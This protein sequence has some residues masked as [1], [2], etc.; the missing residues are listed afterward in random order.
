MTVHAVC[1]AGGKTCLTFALSYL[2]Q[3]FAIAICQIWQSY[4]ANIQCSQINDLASL[5]AMFFFSLT[6]SFDR[7]GFVGAKNFCCIFEDWYFELK[8]EI[9]VFE[10]F[11]III[12][13]TKWDKVFSRSRIFLLYFKLDRHGYIFR[14]T[15]EFD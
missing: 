6:S 2:L 1:N 8:S 9:F 3:I 5:T 7:L 12:S 14:W 11:M 15:H 4:L 10:I 13:Q